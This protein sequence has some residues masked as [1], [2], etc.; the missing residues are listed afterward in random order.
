MIE[1]FA[2]SMADELRANN[3]RSE[4]TR[5][6][7]PVG[8]VAQYYR[9]VEICNRER[10]GW[11]NVFAFQMDD[12]LDWQ[13]R[14]LPL[15]HPLSFEGFMRREVFDKLDA[16]LR[17]LPEHLH[18]PD[19][20]APDVISE[21]I[22]EAGGI[23]TCFGGVGYHGHVAFNDPPISR[24]YKIS[25]DEMRSSLTR[26]VVLGDDSVVVQSIHSTGG[27]PDLV[28]PMAI[29]LGMKDILA[30]RRIRLFLAG[31]ERHRAVFRVTLLADPTADYPSTLVQ[32]HTDCIVHTD[33]ATARPIHPTL[34]WGITPAGG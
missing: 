9:L 8:P 30:S 28:P 22:R 24:W 34:A 4:P 27:S 19:P 5:W 23:D 18:F 21:K 25:V 15:E 32:G 12:F 2:A 20:F 11:R 7:L 29:T 3:A 10:L 14:P 1:H 17:P 6:I 33:E 31:G 16:E 13:G 26:V